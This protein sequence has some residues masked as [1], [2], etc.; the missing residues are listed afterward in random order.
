MEPTTLQIPG[1]VFA[2]RHD[3]VV[4]TMDVARES[5]ALLASVENGAGLECARRQ[6]AGRGRQGRSWSGSGD[7]F[8]GTFLFASRGATHQ[9]SGY[10]LAVGCAVA[11]TLETLG[12][13]VAL[14]WPNDLV[15]VKAGEVSKVGGIL[16]EVQDVGEQRVVLVGIGINVGAAPQEVPGA[17]SILDISGRNLSP[18]GLELP[19]ASRLLAMH[20]RFV[21]QG[22]FY[23]FCG[24][25]MK[26]SCFVLGSTQVEVGLGARTASGTFEGLDPNGALLLSSSGRV[27]AVHSGHVTMLSGLRDTR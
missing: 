10:S 15:S 6:T 24:D 25:W 2:R 27:E 8:M 18:E 21:D 9:F 3:E 5:A 12:A 19:L 1:Y 14:K 20:R 26:R 13:R 16:I 22:G 7:S 11:E 17:T 4:S 23:Q